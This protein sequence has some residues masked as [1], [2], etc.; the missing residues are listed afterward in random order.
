M[1]AHYISYAK[2]IFGGFYTIFWLQTIDP[3]LLHKSAK[4]IYAL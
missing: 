3:H 4:N 2:V 1:S